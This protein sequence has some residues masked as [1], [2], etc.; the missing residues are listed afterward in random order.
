MSLHWRL[1]LI[2]AAISVVCSGTLAFVAY[3]LTSGELIAEVDLDLHDAVLQLELPAGAASPA[4]T[5]PPPGSVLL[6]GSPLPTSSPSGSPPVA[7]VQHLDRAGRVDNGNKLLAI[8]ITPTDLALARRGGAPVTVDQTIGGTPYR[9]LTAPTPAGGAIQVAIS[10]V[11]V[12]HALHALLWQFSLGALGVALLAA[13]VGW[14]L[15]RRIAGPLERLA[16]A[17]SRV[18]RTRVLTLDVD[19]RRPP[20]AETARLTAAIDAMLAS[21]RRSREEQEQ[22]VQDAGHE[23]RTPLTSVCSNVELLALAG[24]RLGAEDRRRLLL[25]ARQE[26]DR[27]VLLVNELIELATD[28]AAAEPLA[29]IEMGELV[30]DAADRCSARSGREISVRAASWT[31]EGR[32]QALE[33]AVGNLLDN[34]A[35]FSPEGT[36]I[37]VEAP[38]GRVVVRDHGPGIDGAD[39]PRVFD[40]FYRAPSTASQPGSGLGLAIV[41]KVALVHQGRVFAAAAPGG[42]AVVGFELPTDPAE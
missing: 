18:E 11:A 17:A 28:T 25:S 32:R 19:R 24:E 41:Q 23:L 35:K 26:L 8:P 29:T 1:A 34:A 39:L 20:R 16:D 6:P 22:L 21:L 36:P 5:P 2:L 3:R 12:D 27:L 38:P 40:R 37:E 42:G 15:A 7:A 30:R 10:L 33:R 13:L 31:V 4:P 14:L 9:V